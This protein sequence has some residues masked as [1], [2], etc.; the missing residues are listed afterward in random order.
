MINCK[1]LLSLD[2]RISQFANSGTSEINFMN[3]TEIQ[4]CFFNKG[5]EEICILTVNLDKLEEQ[6]E[7][8]RRR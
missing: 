7:I 3:L 4:L 1:W 5:R 6:S 2:W 8:R